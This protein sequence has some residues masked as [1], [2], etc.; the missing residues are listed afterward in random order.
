M[1]EYRENAV[2]DYIANNNLDYF[3]CV[4]NNWILVYGNAQ[5]IPKILAF[6]SKVDDINS[7]LSPEEQAS[8]DKSKNI[9]GYFNLPF[10]C[11]RY[12]VNSMMVSVW[13][14]RTESWRRL[15]YDQLRDLYEEYGVGQPGTV[16]KAVNQYVSST[17][18]DWQRNNLGSI[19]VSDLDLIK[20][21]NNHVEQII[22]LKRSKK[23][24]AGWMPYAEDYSNF[25]LLINTIVASRKNISF[26]IFYNLMKDGQIGYR[27]EDISKIKVFDFSI[28]DSF[29]NCQQI[30]FAERGIF[31]LA[32]LLN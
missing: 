2:Y 29:V 22:E 28:P 15:S 6:V 3:Y 13:Q 17:Y 7:K 14:S 12:M 27:E 1:L 24:L 25:A 19:T 10:I 16:R 32:E 11:V 18:H 8:F 26:T 4:E 30:N 23:S 21:R 31:S 9:A 20:C 5:S